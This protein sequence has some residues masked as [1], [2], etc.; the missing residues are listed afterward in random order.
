MSLNDESVRAFGVWWVRG[1]A[2]RRRGW[3]A[4]GPGLYDSCVRGPVDWL[5]RGR[6]VGGRQRGAAR[7]RASHCLLTFLAERTA[8]E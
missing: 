7:W 6:G 5:A 3:L 4:F 2:S 8:D 1:R